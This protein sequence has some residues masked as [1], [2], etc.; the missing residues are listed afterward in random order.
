MKKELFECLEEKDMDDVFGDSEEINE[1]E[2]GQRFKK[3][4]V[5]R[6]QEWIDRKK[7]EEIKSKV[8]EKI[9]HEIIAEYFPDGLPNDIPYSLA[10]DLGMDY[11]KEFS[12]NSVNLSDEEIKDLQNQLIKLMARQSDILS[13][14]LSKTEYDNMNKRQLLG[15]FVNE[16]LKLESIKCNFLD[17]LQA[18]YSGHWIDD[19][20]FKPKFS[21][22]G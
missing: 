18:A 10:S 13:I 15:S 7:D 16:Y 20:L 2:F 4:L 1:V 6:I 12:Y 3:T 17:R 9:R 8:L 5:N 14:F 11:E 19:N 21:E 22:R